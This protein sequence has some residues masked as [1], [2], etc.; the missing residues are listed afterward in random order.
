MKNYLRGWNL[1]RIIRLVIGIIVIG[2]GFYADQ[3]MVVGLGALFTLLPLFNSS[4]CAT[5]GSCAAPR[6][7]ARD[8][9]AEEVTYEEV[10]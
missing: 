9:K 4:M 10:K 8:F 5:T 6:R 7:S 1:T 3:W 2:Q